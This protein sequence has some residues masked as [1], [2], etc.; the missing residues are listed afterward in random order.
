[1]E[2]NFTFITLVSVQTFL[3][4][5]VSPSIPELCLI[6]YQRLRGIFEMPQT[7]LLAQSWQ[8]V[9]AGPSTAQGRQARLFL[10]VGTGDPSA[11][12]VCTNSQLPSCSQTLLHSRAQIFWLWCWNNHWHFL[13]GLWLQI[14]SLSQ[15]VHPSFCYRPC[16]VIA[17]I[18][19]PTRPELYCCQALWGRPGIFC[20]SFFWDVI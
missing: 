7:R 20:A 16:L 12:S 2:W 5:T 10:G 11:L 8:P 15:F 19:D 13:L 9:R 14:R 6:D 4:R 17:P 18:T 1:M 3:F